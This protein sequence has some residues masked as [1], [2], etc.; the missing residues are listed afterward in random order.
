MKNSKKCGIKI[1][2]AMLIFIASI[3]CNISLSK[4]SELSEA[5]EPSEGT[6]D[7]LPSA[8]QERGEAVEI[9]DAEGLRT[10]AADPFGAYLLVAD[11]DMSGEAWTPFAFH[12]SL[13]GDG[14][15]ILNLTVGETGTA[16]KE[17]YDGNM[18]VYDTYFA[19][20]FDE[21]EGA[22][23]RNLN[24][25]NLRIDVET[26]L[27]CFI[28]GITG[29]M[30]DSTIENCEV[31]GNLQLRAHDRMFGVGGIIGYGFGDVKD[32]KA[33]VTLV[34]IDTDASTKDEQF[35]GG[36]CA[37][38]YPNI[39]GCDVAISGF[40]SDHG[41][42]HDG[43]LVGM[44]ILYPKGTQYKGSITDN[45]VTGK[46]TFFEDNKNRRAYC[47]GFIGEIMNWNFENG[48]NKDDFVRDEV[49]TY[50]VD[51]V[52]HACENPVMQEEV[53]APGCEFGYTTYV[54]ETCGYRETDHY[55][56][57]VHDYDWTIL[58]EADLEEEGLREGVCKLCGETAQESIPKVSPE[59]TADPE[60]AADDGAGSIGDSGS[61]DLDA[62]G[63]GVNDEGMTAP[64][65]STGLIIVLMVLVICVVFSII[66]I[67]RFLK[68]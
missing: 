3:S 37:A 21:M 1:W 61:E 47:N 28:G 35:M 65:V 7:M 30:A 52:P 55:T 44:Y 17:T 10:M 68:I 13:D 50:D 12:G 64:K 57:K 27:P 9:W 60:Q 63:E 19:G 4:A 39:N 40:D 29:Y 38:G 45:Y 43:G 31:Q 33:D 49:F 42:V 41:Y 18:K 22:Q 59:P 36:V 48:R 56:L 62:A 6:T 23:V 34:C 11:I 26:D 20:F 32:S 25:I 24:L 54:C 2:A 8:D 46:I 53:T 15:S 66:G 51:L 58:K 16:V 67:I 5:A 14:H